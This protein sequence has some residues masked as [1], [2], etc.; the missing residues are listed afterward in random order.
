MLCHLTP[1]S[2]AVLPPSHDTLSFVD[3]SSNIT[4]IECADD[5]SGVVGYAKAEDRVIVWSRTSG[6]IKL[7]FVD[8]Q[9]KVLAQ[10]PNMVQLTRFGEKAYCAY[11]EAEDEGSIVLLEGEELEKRTVVFKHPRKAREGRKSDAGP[12]A[13]AFDAHFSC[14]IFTRKDTIFIFR[15]SSNAGEINADE[16]KLVFTLKNREDITALATGFVSGSVDGELTVCTGSKSGK[17]RIYRVMG[18]AQK[19][20]TQS[21]EHHWHSG[22]VNTLCLVDQNHLVSGGEEGVIVLWR[23]D[24]GS[25]SMTFRPRLGAAIIAGSVLP[26]LSSVV[27]QQLVTPS[28]LLLLADGCVLDVEIP[29]LVLNRRIRAWIPSNSLLAV[30]TGVLKQDDSSKY[31][32]VALDN[33]RPGALTFIDA[34]LR[35]STAE[36]HVLDVAIRN[37]VS[38]ADAASRSRL[39]DAAF[40]PNGKTLAAILST[41]GKPG[42]IGGRTSVSSSRKWELRVVYKDQEV[43]RVPL[44]LGERESAIDSE[45]P[46]RRKF[47]RRSLSVTNES[48]ALVDPNATGKILVFKMSTST[49]T[50]GVPTGDF[51]LQRVIDVDPQRVVAVSL[52]DDESCLACLFSNGAVRV[53]NR[54]TGK[55]AATHALMQGADDGVAGIGFSKG[56]RELFVW[57]AHRIDAVLQRR[58]LSLAGSEEVLVWGIVTP[59]L[60]SI[61]FLLRNRRSQVKLYTWNGEDKDA[62]HIEAVEPAPDWAYVD[63]CGTTVGWLLQRASGSLQT[64]GGKSTVVPKRKEVKA[65][66]NKALPSLQLRK[67]KTQRF[68]GQVSVESA[69]SKKH[70]LFTT[71]WCKDLPSH[72]LSAPPALEVVW[73]SWEVKESLAPSVTKKQRATMI[74]S[75]AALQMHPKRQRKDITS[76]TT[77]AARN[78][79]SSLAIEE[80]TEAQREL[81]E[82]AFKGGANGA[83]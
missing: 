77:A 3:A 64:R 38:T 44:S 30:P 58:S 6:Q 55:V 32:A 53:W 80:E 27:D 16:E 76:S 47:T 54:A 56:S 59:A 1:T 81:L 28:C 79:A 35:D 41:G 60:D 57:N 39:E 18:E 34:D 65:S 69:E 63:Y 75:T 37:A 14:A 12:C 33:H 9:E 42:T 67:D 17:I 61:G 13:Y 36:E 51:V 43:L 74:E 62:E 22:P 48:I 21:S 40:S 2:F 26:W 83:H 11:C 78:V 20:N 52:S 73:P 8:G 19:R 50:P 72:L 45:E 29:T 70:S 71:E 25:A 82:K 24:R 5:E 23:L 49:S 46:S 15:R 4:R 7:R 66:A 10:V 31:L 68:Q